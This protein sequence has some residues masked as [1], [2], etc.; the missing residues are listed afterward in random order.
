M[1]ELGDLANS[2]YVT[3]FDSDSESANLSLIS[4]WFVE[5]IGLLNT[6]IYTNFTGEDPGL[7]LEEK[8][9]YKQIY[10]YNYYNKQARN[11]LRGITST[12]TSDNIIMVADEGNRIQFTNKNEVGKTYKD[13]AKDSKQTLDS[14]VAKYNIYAAKPLQVAGIETGTDAYDSGEE[15]NESDEPHE[16]DIL[17]GGEDTV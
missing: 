15:H 1:S 12:A 3:E 6:L 14:L 7:G 13:I 11:V 2:I 17:D 4:G 16:N 8:A 10:M 5:N 9:I